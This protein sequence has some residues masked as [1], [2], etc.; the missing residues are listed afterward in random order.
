[1]IP[2]RPPGRTQSGSIF[3]CA[4]FCLITLTLPAFGQLIPAPPVFSGVILSNNQRILNWTPY[5]GAQQYTILST[6]NLGQPFLTNASGTISGFTWTATNTSRIEFQLLQV[7]PMD[8]NALLMA[9]V[10]NRLCYGPTP[11][12]LDQLGTNNIQPFIDSQLNPETIVETVA[13]THTNLPFLSA[14][15]AAATN[16]LD[17]QRNYSYVTNTNTL[18]ITTNLSIASTNATLSDFR[19]WHTL[20]AIGA[21]RQLLE[22]LLQFLENHFVTQYTKTFTYFNGFYNGDANFM[23]DRLATQMEFLENDRWRNALLN[24]Q[25]TFYDLLRISAESPAMIIYLDTVSSRGDRGNIANENYARELMELFTMGVDNGYD[26]ADIT[27]L[28][29]CWTGWTVQIVDD[30]NAFNPFAPRTTNVRAGVSNNVTATTNLAGVWAFNFNTNNHN[31]NSKSI[32]V[33]TN[34]TSKTVP[35]RFGPPYTTQTYG[36]NATPGAYQ[37]SLPSRN[38]TNGIQD[39]YDV[40]Q[41]LSTLPF[42]EEYISIKLCRLF[43]H[44]GFPNPNNDPTNP[45]YDFYNYAAGNLSPEAQ[46]V[47]D[48]MSA[49]ENNNPKGQI[50][51]VLQIIFN[52]ALFR[53]HGASLQKVKTPLEF[54]IS[55]V[56]A[57]RSSTNG[58]DTAGSYSAQSDGYS[59]AAALSRMGGMLLFDRNDPNGYPEDANGWISGGT[60]AERIRFAQAFCIASS[61]SGHSDAGNCISD[62]VSLMRFKFPQQ[63]PPKILLAAGDVADY[64]LGIL[65]PGEGAGNLSLYRAAAINFLNDGSADSP[66]A[67]ATPFGGLIVS[68]V[69]ASTY[70]TRVRG[71]VAF[72]LATQRFQEQ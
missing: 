27:T 31:T 35:A 40:I 45:S 34:G 12:L 46:L 2:R 67:T 55:T 43:V 41:Y 11:D 24:P 15:L 29:R 13:A 53:G 21:K 61:Q 50:R 54:V 17:L 28:S 19:A 49:W 48:C 58:T 32:F 57:L 25:C 71:M 62:P 70:D 38:G 66:T 68:S 60:L 16:I 23:E 9:T 72:L 63:T 14:K 52:S 22:V 36:A 39:G 42:T 64:F 47:R 37:L 59:F 44:D 33:T 1:M 10:L 51:P 8:S 65:F 7:T 5:P 18:V 30:T 3:L 4:C 26:Q 20:R 56:R 69:A 6:T